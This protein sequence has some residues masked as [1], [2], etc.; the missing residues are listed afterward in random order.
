M[1]LTE[2]LAFFFHV[3]AVEHLQHT[4]TERLAGVCRQI[5]GVQLYEQLHGLMAM[6]ATGPGLVRPQ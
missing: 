4:I 6:P 3:G 5:T 1:S 2:H